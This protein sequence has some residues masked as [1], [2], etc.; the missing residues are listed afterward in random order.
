MTVYDSTAV[1]KV[2]SDLYAQIEEQKKRANIYRE[3]VLDCHDAIDRLEEENKKLKVE[4]TRT[5]K[6]LE[7]V[8]SS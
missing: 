1:G 4:L 5:K 7:A 2:I 8:L 6:M 3:E